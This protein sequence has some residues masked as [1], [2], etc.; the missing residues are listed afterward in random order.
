MDLVSLATRAELFE[1]EAVWVIAPA[2]LGDVVAFLALCA[3]QSDL[4]TND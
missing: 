3:G 4:G 1:V 2:L